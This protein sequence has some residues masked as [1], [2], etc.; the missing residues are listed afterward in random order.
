MIVIP[1]NII[2][3]ITKIFLPFLRERIPNSNPVRVIT[4][5]KQVIVSLPAAGIFLPIKSINNAPSH[6][7]ILLNRL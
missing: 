2:P 7:K 6:E 1:L 4:K 3:R 5:N